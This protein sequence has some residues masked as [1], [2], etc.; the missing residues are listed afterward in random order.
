LYV[1]FARARVSLR[2][3]GSPTQVAG[4]VL[5]AVTAESQLCSDGVSAFLHAWLGFLTHCAGRGWCLLA[6]S[7]LSLA[8][9]GAAQPGVEA[10]NVAAAAACAGLGFAHL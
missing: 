4:L 9:L 2:R 6:L 1:L 10:L 7:L 5:V 8:T 3:V